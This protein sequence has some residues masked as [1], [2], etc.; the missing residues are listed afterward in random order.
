MVELKWCTGNISRLKGDA[1]K[2]RATNKYICAYKR[3]FVILD[4][5]HSLASVSSL[6]VWKQ[7]IAQ[8]ASTMAMNE[9][10]TPT[11]R[12]NKNSEN[13][14]RLCFYHL[15]GSQSRCHCADSQFLSSWQFMWV[16]RST[17][18]FAT[19]SS[20]EKSRESI[21]A[22]FQKRFFILFR[23]S[24]H[25]SDKLTEKGGLVPCRDERKLLNNGLKNNAS[26]AGIKKM[27]R[28]GRERNVMNI[29]KLRIITIV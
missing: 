18:I 6:R 29:T 17:V 2:K 27:P 22:A 10:L 23:A 8:P 12:W 26:E 13:P 19:H 11:P 20:D 4:S 16:G 25:N 14:I 1:K 21:D 24:K 5:K 3:I 28:R 15:F 7:I 9:P